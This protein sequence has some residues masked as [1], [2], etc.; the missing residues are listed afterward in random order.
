MHFY[1]AA[2]N[3]FMGTDVPLLLVPK[4]RSS[5]FGAK[6]FISAVALATLSTRDTQNTQKLVYCAIQ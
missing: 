1:F 6:L 2:S 4:W 3:H 5:H